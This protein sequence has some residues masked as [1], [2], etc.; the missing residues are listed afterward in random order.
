MSEERQDPKQVAGFRALARRLSDGNSEAR[1]EEALRL[2]MSQSQEE[3][4][5]DALL[6]HQA[7]AMKRDQ[8]L[9]A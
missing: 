3:E 4:P 9:K 7:P 6:P 1:F 8:A 2:L 5:V